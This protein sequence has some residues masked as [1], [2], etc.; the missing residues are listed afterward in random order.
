MATDDEKSIIRNLRNIKNGSQKMI[1]IIISSNDSVLII[2]YKKK[3]N[4]RLRLGL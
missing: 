4:G 1:I 2:V 3:Q